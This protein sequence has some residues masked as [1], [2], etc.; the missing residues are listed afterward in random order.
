[1]RKGHASLTASVVAAARALASTT[2]GALLDP[3]DR[4]VERLL[5]APFSLAL[6]ALRTADRGLGWLSTG[7]THASLGMVDHIALRT[8]AIDARLVLELERGT[9]QLVIV[10]AGLDTRAHR[11]RQLHGASVYEVDHPDSQRQKRQRTEQLELRARSLAYVALDLSE[12]GLRDRLA[13]AGHRNTEPSVFVVEGLVPYLDR[14]AL[15][16]TLR[17]ISM[18]AAEGSRLL[19]TYI[20]PELIWLRRGRPLLL[21][22]MR[23]LGEPLHSAQ[24]ADEMAHMLS[25]EGFDVEQDTDTRDWARALC[26]NPARQPL[27]AYERLVVA[28][29]T[30]GAQP[31][32]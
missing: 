7:V 13:E 18:A 24:S 21:A 25:A 31:R 32:A 15:A 3:E 2:R 23:L 27:I 5:P 8:A 26:K 19:L 1:M 10:G 4:V 9:R 30:A 28:V 20:T 11:L 29:K 12:G 22:S 6:R 17:E 16:S 14:A